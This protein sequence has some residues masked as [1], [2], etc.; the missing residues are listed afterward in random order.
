[1]TRRLHDTGRSGWW[2]VW[3]IITSVVTSY[4]ENAAFG[5]TNYEVTPTTGYIDMFKAIMENSMGL[6]IVV[7]L[8]YLIN[9]GIS[10]SIFV[11]SLLDSHKEENKYGPS[12]KYQ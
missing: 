5:L 8:L 2:V 11:F 4:A 3:C 7:A 10:I 1:M 12:P 9:L 6:F